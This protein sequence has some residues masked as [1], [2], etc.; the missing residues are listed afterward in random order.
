MIKKYLI[1]QYPNI[2]EEVYVVNNHESDS[3]FLEFFSG[4]ESG[5]SMFGGNIYLGEIK[6]GK[7]FDSEDREI[8]LSDKSLQW[9]LSQEG[10]KFN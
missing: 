5:A 8:N 9:V 4:M 1:Y 3:N 2:P 10:C 7:V 6:D